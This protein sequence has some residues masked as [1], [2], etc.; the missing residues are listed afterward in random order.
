MVL[1]AFL[2]SDVVMYFMLCILAC[3]LESSVQLFCNHRDAFSVQG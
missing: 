1:I 2:A 3:F